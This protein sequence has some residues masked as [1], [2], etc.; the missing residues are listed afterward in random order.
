MDTSELSL[1]LE[2]DKAVDYIDFEEPTDF[3]YEYKG[4]IIGLTEDE[5]RHIVGR[6]KVYYADIANGVNAGLGLLD[7]LDAYATTYE[8]SALFE[9]GDFSETV[10]KR[11]S[12]E[13]FYSNIMII[14]RI[15]ILPRFRGKGFGPEVLKRLVHRFGHGAS[16]VALKA[17][18]LQFEKN[19][20]SEE[21][22]SAWRKKMR[23]HDFPTTE[24]LAKKALRAY[25][26]N[27]G[28]LAPPK[29]E[30]MFANLA[31]KFPR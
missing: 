13:L 3:V 9:D 29:S 12:Y 7:V 11:C 15:E 28:F 17:F 14:E 4:N 22:T 19:L 8:F 10:Q 18:P 16:L 26:K 24:S 25:Y 1:C 23:L 27:L 31:R 2:F 20:P 5:H 30:L 6:F 21:Q